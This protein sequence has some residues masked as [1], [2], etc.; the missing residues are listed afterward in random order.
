MIFY[1]SGTGNSEYIAKLLGERTCEEVMDMAECV[2]SSMEYFKLKKGER[3][4]FVYPIYCWGLPDIVEKFIKN[5]TFAF[6]G[7]HYTYSVA[8]CGLSTGRADEDL[9][10]LLKAKHIPMHAS[11]A[12]KM[13]DNYTVITNVK[14]KEKNEKINLEAKDEITDMLFMVHSKVGGYYNKRRGIWPVSHAVHKG[15]ALCRITKPFSVSDECIGCGACAKKCPS[16]A[17]VMKDG[18]P[19][20]N[21]KSCTMC[22]SC[23]HRCPKN[24]INYGPTTKRN[25]QYVF[26][27]NADKECE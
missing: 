3:L 14:N 6:Y 1:F 16:K 7:K 17:I 21:K 2:N 9:A 4:G 13:V 15:Y 19:V 11:F 20:W 26:E 22:F 18:K 27:E 25:G 12:I 5:T 8:T 24:A 10:Q 23:L